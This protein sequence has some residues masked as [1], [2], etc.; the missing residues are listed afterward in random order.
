[1]VINTIKEVKKNML[2]EFMENAAIIREQI[3]NLGR[4]SGIVNKE[5]N[6]NPRTEKSNNGNGKFIGWNHE[7]F[8]VKPATT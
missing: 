2:E 1:M 6:G 3:R 7:L 8:S 4:E 5:H